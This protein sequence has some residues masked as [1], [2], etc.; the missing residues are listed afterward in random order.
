MSKRI[1]T[2]AIGVLLAASLALSYSAGCDLNIGTSSGRGQG[3]DVIE[4]VW[5]IIFQDYVEKDELDASMLS[6]A[7]IKGIVE[8]LDDPY[9]SYLDKKNYI[10]WSL[11]LEGKYEGIG[12]YV[13]VRDEKIVIIAPILNSP[14]AEAGIRAGDIILEVDGSS[15]SDMSLEEV[16]LHVRGPEGTSVR[17]LVLHE[18]ESEP[19]EIEIVRAKIEVPSVYYEM[20]EDIAYVFI[21]H[22]TVRTNEEISSVLEDMSGEE[23]EGI[24]LDIRSNPGGSVESVVDVTSHFLDEGVVFY[25]VDNRDKTTTYPVESGGI[26]TDL[27]MVV[28]TDNY[29]ASGSEVLAGALQDYERAIIA[30]TRTFGKGSVNTLYQ[31]KDGS[32]LL[33]TTARWFT[34]NGRMIEGEGITPNYELELEGE[35]AIQWAIDYL[36]GKGS[37]ARDIRNISAEI[38]QRV[39]NGL[40]TNL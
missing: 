3:L 8:A 35:D 28:L 27:P 9:T 2:I 13:G 33:I 7:A 34:P 32:G 16:I 29:S 24:V 15:T 31:L 26:T 20:R 39:P 1:K 12:A 19:E 40:Y 38:L 14:A 22:F 25:V 10:E 37:V 23:A 4:E 30:G 36:K 21:G 18:D 5:G 11:D 6:Q 17:L